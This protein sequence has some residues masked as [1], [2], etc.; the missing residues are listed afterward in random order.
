M[1][2]II[3]FII[4]CTIGLF[5]GC[6]KQNQ[7]SRP[8]VS[9]VD[10]SQIL[11]KMQKGKICY[12]SNSQSL[13]DIAKG[14]ME[15]YFNEFKKDNVS[16]DVKITDFTIN[17][18]SD[19]EGDINKFN[20]YVIYTNKPSDINLYVLAGNGELKDSWII[21]RTYYVQVK[22]VDDKYVLTNI[23]TGK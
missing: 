18:I 7:E 4:I 20:F 6:T 22:K 23:G 15:S 19:V 21:N 9:E 3:V 2:K 8:T 17:K 1:K 13:E 10:G 12:Q 14:I 11:E 5:V 16:K